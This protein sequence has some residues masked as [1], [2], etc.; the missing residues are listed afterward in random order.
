MTAAAM[1]AT[2]AI[3]RVA[4]A[5]ALMAVAEIVRVAAAASEGQ[6]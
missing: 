4:A 2:A 6:L 5:S 3:V 1:T